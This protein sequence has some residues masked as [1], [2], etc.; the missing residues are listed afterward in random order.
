MLGNMSNMVQKTKKALGTIER[1]PYISVFEVVMS[2]TANLT[3]VLCQSLKFC[4]SSVLNGI[5]TVLEWGC[6]V[7]FMD[8][9]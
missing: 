5:E 4:L 6:N 2:N 1:S 3:F 7:W 8:S 9:R